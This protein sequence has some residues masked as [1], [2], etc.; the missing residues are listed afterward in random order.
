MGVLF[1][2][3]YLCDRAFRKRARV[4]LFSVLSGEENFNQAIDFRRMFFH[5][6]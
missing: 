4:Y 5:L 3:N 6:G 2:S 1:F